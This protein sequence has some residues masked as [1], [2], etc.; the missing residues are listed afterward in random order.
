MAMSVSAEYVGIFEV[1]RGGQHDVAV[2]HRIRHHDVG[3]HDEQ[4]FPGECSA[5]AILV[6]MS[7]DGIV[8][9]DE[10]RLDR[11]AQGLGEQQA[12]DVHD[13]GR[14]CAFGHEV[15]ALQSGGGS[16]KGMAGLGEHAGAKAA[17]VAGEC[18]Q[19]HGGA[20]AGTATV[21][22]ANSF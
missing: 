9:V 8:V 17:V 5:H 7:R 21:S 2:P 16:R 14:T 3:S 10:N 22:T 19:R 6:G 18:L 12:G 1:A 13:I 11:R 20:Q 15:R 4:I